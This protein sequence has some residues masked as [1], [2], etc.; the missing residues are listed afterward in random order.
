MRSRAL[1]KSMFSMFQESWIAGPIVA[2]HVL[3]LEISQPPLG[4]SERLLGFLNLA[5]ALLA[6]L[7]GF[8]FFLARFPF[9]VLLHPLGLLFSELLTLELGGRRLRRDG[10]RFLFLASPPL[11]GLDRSRLYP[12]EQAE[13]DRRAARA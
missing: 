2:W 9:R 3:A 12:G 1:V 10:V 4:F 5:L 6:L 8:L 13:T 7:S 11:L